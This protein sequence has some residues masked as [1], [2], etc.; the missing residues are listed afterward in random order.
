[1]SPVAL[2]EA[3]RR[4]ERRSVKPRRGGAVEPDRHSRVAK[5]AESA[6]IAESRDRRADADSE[7]LSA[8]RD[9]HRLTG[10]ELAHEIDRALMTLPAARALLK[11]SARE[12]SPE[13]EAL[14]AMV[15]ERVYRRAQRRSGQRMSARTLR[16]WDR[17]VGLG[18]VERLFCAPYGSES[19]DRRSRIL[20]SE[21]GRES[22]P[23]VTRGSVGREYLSA[24][25]QGLL[26][27]SREWRD[28]ADAYTTKRDRQ[29]DSGPMIVGAESVPVGALARAVAARSANNGVPMAVV[30]EGSAALAGAMAQ[31]IADG[32]SARERE[33]VT[34][35]LLGALDG[36]PLSAI[37][38]A[39]GYSIATAKR[40]SAAGGKLIRE[41]Y[42]A[43]DIAGEVIE[44]AR[45][46]HA[47]GPDHSGPDLV[48]I[49]AQCERS[50]VAALA[51]VDSALTDA[52]E[53]AQLLVRSGAVG[54]TPRA[55]RRNVRAEKLTGR[56]GRSYPD[57]LRPCSPDAPWRSAPSEAAHPSQ[58]E[59]ERRYREQ[60]ERNREAT[61]ATAER[62]AALRAECPWGHVIPALPVGP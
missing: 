19:A 35:A 52:R 9:P 54:S 33:S 58:A 28:T 48:A 21:A 4:P 61:T 30:P 15:A 6:A 62:R 3:K 8:L 13:W 26:R 32:L 44:A 29:R 38:A 42:I 46:L 7:A 2:S 57:P 17:R 59:R 43:G 27:D 25:G 60:L 5:D 37:A 11:S 53:R 51:A 18:P 40:H 39:R 55:A 1:M 31:R 47:T 50:P 34:V 49:G 20:A 12:R 22:G 36:A 45:E 23:R 24:I 41:R 16:Q 56:Y 14:A 10:A